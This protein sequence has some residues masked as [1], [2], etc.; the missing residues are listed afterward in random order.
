MELKEMAEQAVKS[1]APAE[2]WSRS[3]HPHCAAHKPPVT[4]A[5]ARSHPLLKATESTFTPAQTTHKHIIL[6]NNAICGG[7]HL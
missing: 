3:Q 2:S 7:P 6:K 4:P 5:P 1:I